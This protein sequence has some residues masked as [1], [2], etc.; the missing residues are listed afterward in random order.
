MKKA[1]PKFKSEKQEKVFW[2][3]NDSADYLDWSGA[4]KVVLSGLTPSVKS[5][6]LRLPESMVAQ[7]KLLASKKDI[8]YQSLM[9]IFLAERIKQEFSH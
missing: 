6:S 3:K 2:Q 5:I 4:K 1:I 7:L 8:P 9:K